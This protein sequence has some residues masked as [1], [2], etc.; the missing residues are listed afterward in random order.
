MA[1]KLVFYNVAKAVGKFCPNNPDDVLLV[2]FFIRRISQA[3]DVMGPFSDLP[4]TPTFD[5]RLAEAIMWFQK[6][7]ASKNANIYADGKVDP[8][9][10]P[11]KGT[12]TI[13]HMN[14]T[15]RRRYPQ[16]QHAIEADPNLPA[17]LNPSLATA[18][19]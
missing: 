7:A 1:S 13:R 6:T 10:H 12:Y 14:A 17:A 19:F 9:P 18:E 15:Y 11:G 8:E 3:P 4:M 5:N 16:F 2:R